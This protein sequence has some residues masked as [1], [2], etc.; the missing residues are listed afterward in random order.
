MGRIEKANQYKASK[1]ASAPAAPTK[2]TAWQQISNVAAQKPV[3]DNSASKPDTEKVNFREKTLQNVNEQE[4]GNMQDNLNASNKEYYQAQFKKNPDS[5]YFLLRS[6][7]ESDETPEEKRKRERRDALGET[8]RNL[9]NVIGNAANLYYTNK[10]GRYIDLNTSNERHNERMRRIKDK[11]DALKEQRERMYA[12]AKLDDFKNERAQRAAQA[13]AANKSREAQL[14]HQRE[15]VK[16]Q[17]EHAFKLGQIDAETK[18]RLLIQADKSNSDKQ[19]E[20]IKHQNRM[21]L[22][23]TP[24][25]E[26]NKVL[27]SLTGRDGHAYTRNSKMDDVEIRE[28]SK[29]VEDFEPYTT[30]DEDGNK[31]IDYVGAIADAAES[32]LIPIEVLVER[33]FKKGKSSAKKEGYSYAKDNKKGYSYK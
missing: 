4:F 7:L 12:N 8:F 5:S 15:M 6:Y 28:L 26:Q 24:S 32:G 29:Y 21:T 22:K 10:G 11:Q 19:L 33:G 30:L 2:P 31:S 25:S 17:I 3:L 27:T 18:S 20:S 1:A 16:M 13:S 23:T 9:G 14:A